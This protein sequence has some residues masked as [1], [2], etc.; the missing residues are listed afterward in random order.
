MGELSDYSGPDQSVAL[1][2]ETPAQVPMRVPTTEAL[3]RARWSRD[4]LLR[5]LLA[6]AD[7]V[8]V[9]LASASLALWG[10]SLDQAFFST[11]LAPVWIL[12]A[13]IGGLYDRDQRELRHLTIDEMPRLFLC[14]LSGVAMTALAFEF[15]P[16]SPLTP[17]DAVRMLLF[18]FVCM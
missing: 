17:A 13:K 5:R 4:A 8:S 9:G 10:G 2:V 1:E 11:A 12:L 7:V 6:L 16:V 15:L 18:V 14:G 3:R